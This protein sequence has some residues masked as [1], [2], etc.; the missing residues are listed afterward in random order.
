[1]SDT[2][3]NDALREPTEEA[4]VEPAAAPSPEPSPAPSTL[5]GLRTGTKVA[6]AALVVGVGALGVVGGSFMGFD[7]DHHDRDGFEMFRHHEEFRHHQMFGRDQQDGWG[8]GGGPM[9]GMQGGPMNGMQGPRPT[10]DA[11]ITPDESTTTA[12]TN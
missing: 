9:N 11:P 8:D 6:L 1:M 7:G 2:P 4:T 3:N 5:R 12:P 10:P